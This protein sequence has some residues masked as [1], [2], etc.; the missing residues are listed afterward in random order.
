[1]MNHPQPPMEFW[2]E[3]VAVPHEKMFAEGM[4]KLGALYPIML[5]ITVAGMLH[6]LY[7]GWEAYTRYIIALDCIINFVIFLVW[8][9]ILLLLPGIHARKTIRTMQ[10]RNFGQP[11]VMVRQFG[12]RIVSHTPGSV[13][14]LDYCNIKNVR[15]L[16]YS[17]VIRFSENMATLFLPRDGFTKGT[18][19]EFKQ[20][21]RYK[22]PD[23]NI[24]E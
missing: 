10:K 1:M 8:F 20:F 19:E 21:L 14:V 23:L 24:P 6:S 11:P 18:F 4:R 22:R 5:M 2:F 7:F 17:Y 15:S 13:I 9:L 16:Q 3:N 12:E